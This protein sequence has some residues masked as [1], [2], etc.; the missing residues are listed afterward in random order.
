MIRRRAF[1]WG[2]VCLAAGWSVVLAQQRTA[3]DGI[4][5]AAEAERGAAVYGRSCVA[6]HGEDLGGD[7]TAPALAGE[8]FAFQWTDTT[9]KDLFVRIKTLM[10]PD[11]PDSLPAE[12]YRDLVAFILRSNKMPAGQQALASEPDTLQQIRITTAPH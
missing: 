10:P 2:A 7:G 1:A 11:R 9:V 8:S 4:Y 12:T 3:W 5:T 6:C